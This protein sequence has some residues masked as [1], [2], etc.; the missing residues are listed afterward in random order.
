[1]EAVEQ[2]E[3]E[4]AAP[5]KKPAKKAAPAPVKTA[6]KAKAQKAETESGYRAGSLR[7]T[8]YSV[9]LGAKNNADAV[10]RLTAKSIRL[11][12]LRLMLKE[13][14]KAMAHLIA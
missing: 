1:V 9:C 7:D 4:I 12:F 6:K 2:A 10:K 3:E 13:H 5:T 8:A 14:S 11:S